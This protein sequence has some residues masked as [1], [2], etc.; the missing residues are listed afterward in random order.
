MIDNYLFVQMLELQEA[1]VLVVH[2][3]QPMILHHHSYCRPE[4]QMKALNKINNYFNVE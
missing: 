1:V 3:Q 2:Y 4:M